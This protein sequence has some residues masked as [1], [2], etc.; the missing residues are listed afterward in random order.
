[1]PIDNMIIVD[2]VLRVFTCGANSRNSP[3]PDWEYAIRDNRVLIPRILLET[4]MNDMISSLSVTTTPEMAPFKQ[5][6]RS[7]KLDVGTPG[8]LDTLRFVTD[9]EREHPLV[10]DDIEIEVKGVSLNFKDVMI[11]MGQLYEPALGLDCSGIVSRVGPA[12]TK[13]KP[14]D[15]VMTWKVGTFRTYTRASESMC[16]LIPEHMS[17]RIAA[18]LPIVYTTAYHA[19]FNVA[20]LEKGETILIHGGAGGVGQAAIVLS[21]FIGAKVLVTVS[22]GTK[23]DLLQG[24]Y[25]ISEDC[26][27]NS[28][29]D[30]FAKGVMRMTNQRGVDVVLNSLAGEALQQSWNCIARDV[31]NTGLNM[32]PFIRNVSFHSINLLDI[33]AYKPIKAAKIFQAV[34]ELV[35]QNVVKPLEPTVFM[36]FSRIEESFRMMQ[37]GKHMGKIVLEPTGHDIVPV[38]PR[39]LKPYRFRSNA[40]YLLSGGLGG[41]GRSIALWMSNNGA[42]NI[43]FL[44]RSGSKKPEAQE[45]MDHLVKRGVKVAVY[46]C[47]VADAQQVEKAIRQCGMTFPPIKGA[48]QGAM[49]LR[50]A[51]YE[52]CTHEQ[53]M[54]AIRP[55]VHGSWNLHKYLPK[56]MDF[57]VMLSS[58]AG[59]VGSRGQGNYSAGNTYQDALAYHRRLQGQCGS[60]ID[61]GL[62]LGVGFV[63]QNKEQRITGNL[64]TWN[65]VGIVEKELH[66]LLQCAITGENAIGNRIPPQM[67]TGLGTG[68]MANFAREK[69]PWWF[70]D[71]K[72]T[73]LKHVDIH[74][75]TADQG[76]GT[77]QLQ[78]LLAQVTS[79]NDAAKHVTEA[80]VQKLARSMMV[81]AENID[82]GKPISSYGVDSLLAVEIRS[83]LFTEVQAD[84]SVFELLS[85]VP[86]TTLAG[87]LVMKSKCVPRAVIQQG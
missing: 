17:F 70:A 23:K 65:F 80:L 1:M 9:L 34:M 44:S 42:K 7:L 55:K 82:S 4:G 27:F 3:R 13:F 39:G 20:R 54:G 74:K 78:S 61:L 52:N 24:K 59:I 67:V 75:T 10:D 86:I 18:S 56:D 14:G 83:W 47:D 68:G 40:T 5:P 2:K 6:G 69:F 46:N 37:T 62:I 31:Q 71:A 15:R 25:D 11:A 12:A 58:S 29:S 72:F 26:I 84:I 41:I 57:F 79:V 16:Q 8:R 32:A 19:L 45:V 36:P 38:L 66:A 43:V 51:V 22:N 63:A 73:H 28:R 76:S 35:R 64:Q 81:E 30:S 49:V 33:L 48:V 77:V 21:Q 53:W 50:D 85:N 60:S 87:N